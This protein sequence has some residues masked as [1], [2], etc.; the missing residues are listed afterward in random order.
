M[1]LLQK[2]F[3]QTTIRLLTIFIMILM[4]QT[5]FYFLTLNTFL[6]YVPIELSFQIQRT[7]R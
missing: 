4:S 5:T 6:A 7:N 1:K 2:P 3:P